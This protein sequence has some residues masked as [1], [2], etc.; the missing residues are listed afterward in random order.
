MTQTIESE[1]A[2]EDDPILQDVPEGRF[3]VKNGEVYIRFR[4]QEYSLKEHPEL[5]YHLEKI[6]GI[7]FWGLLRK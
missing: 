6:A 2:R 4:D 5:E 7:Y 1:L 3:F